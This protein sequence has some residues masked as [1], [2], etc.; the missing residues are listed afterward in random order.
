MNN[1]T[2][3]FILLL[4]V[5][6]SQI[7]CGH[8]QKR[9]EDAVL[10][11]VAASL[12][13]VMTELTDSFQVKYNVKV[14]L[15]MASSGTLARQIEHGGDA[16][17]YISASMRWANYIDSLGY[18]YQ[19]SMQDVAHNKLVVIV[20]SDSEIDTLEIDTA[21]DLKSLL[22]TQYFSL[23]NPAHVPAG[24]YAKQAL[25]YYNQYEILE[26]NLLL[27][28]DV[29]SA[30][31]TVEM[32]EAAMGIVYSTDALKSKKV[33]IVGQFSNCSHKTIKYVACLLNDACS[34]K[35]FY[36]YINAEETRCIWKKYGFEK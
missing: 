28:K 5:V 12:T 34:E 7:A 24:K 4:L 30:L 18:I 15:N 35:M 11:Y 2:I 29:R 32:G 22:G 17:V 20:P 1:K 26:E 9:E 14:N 10:V 33:K 6:V 16:G 3:N 27:A 21:L 23:G 19:D 25:N 8:K 36:Q 31:M 13:E